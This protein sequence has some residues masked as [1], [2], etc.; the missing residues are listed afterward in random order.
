M[1]I[2]IEYVKTVKCALIIP[3]LGTFWF[4]LKNSI[5]VFEISLIQIF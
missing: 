3:C 1:Q 4:Q 2:F 5:V